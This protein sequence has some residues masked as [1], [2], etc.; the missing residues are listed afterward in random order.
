MY[1]R[2]KCFSHPGIGKFFLLD[3]HIIGK[4]IACILSQLA[5]NEMYRI[6]FVF[7]AINSNFA[8]MCVC[9]EE[10]IGSFYNVRFN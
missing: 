10:I 9:D 3:V 5:C 6:I 4:L 2:D 1:K 8:N 7:F